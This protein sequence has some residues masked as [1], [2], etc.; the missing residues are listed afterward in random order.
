MLSRRVFWHNAAT[1]G[2]NDFICSTWKI[3]IENQE[4]A[5]KRGG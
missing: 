5:S 3:E 4:R 2:G 1:R